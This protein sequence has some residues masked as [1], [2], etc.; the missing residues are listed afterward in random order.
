MEIKDNREEMRARKVTEKLSDGKNCRVCGSA[1]HYSDYNRP[2]MAC[3]ELY[4][5]EIA[6]LKQTIKDDYWPQA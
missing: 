6:Y 1:K 4:R 2:T 5:E 3:I